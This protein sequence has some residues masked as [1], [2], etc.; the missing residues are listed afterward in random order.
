MGNTQSESENYAKSFIKKS[1]QLFVASCK[2]H[3]L[4]SH[5]KNDVNI[6]CDHSVLLTII[7]D[8]VHNSSTTSKLSKHIWATHSRSHLGT[9]RHSMSHTLG[10]Y[11]NYI[12]N[13]SSM[14]L[15]WSLIMQDNKISVDVI[16][17]SCNN[18]NSTHFQNI[19]FSI[20]QI[21]DYNCYCCE[22]IKEMYQNICK[23]ITPHELLNI[24][25][26]KDIDKII[27]LTNTH[28][29]FTKSSFT[30]A[31]LSQILNYPT[32]ANIIMS[33]EKQIIISTIID[34]SSPTELYLIDGS[35]IDINE[36]IANLDILTSKTSKLHKITL[37][38]DCEMSPLKKIHQINTPNMF[39]K[40]IM[41]ANC[42]KDY[43]F[44]QHV[45]IILFRQYYLQHAHLILCQLPLS[46]DIIKYILIILK[47]C[48]S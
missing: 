2:Y 17:A 26:N 22:A 13:L 40:H 41:C 15:L 9:I 25:I 36:R 3:K 14:Q 42:F 20:L 45:P 8:V 18:A 19:V 44:K 1:F 31:K 43:K 28:Q 34:K 37:S 4:L 11:D 24:I 47:E 7:N 46:Q 23:L 32:Y 38:N 21:E 33:L 16:Q 48:I 10:H 35:P 5:V 12:A 30:E 39:D 6:E 27:S 29:M